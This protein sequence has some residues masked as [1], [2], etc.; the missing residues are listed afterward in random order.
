MVELSREFYFDNIVGGKYDGFPA[1]F[2]IHT[3]QS[4]NPPKNRDVRLK[5]CF[6]D[7][8]KIREFN[9]YTPIIGTSYDT[10]DKF[11][12]GDGWAYNFPKFNDVGSA[13][14]RREK[15]FTGVANLDDAFRLLRMEVMSEGGKVSEPYFI[16]PAGREFLQELKRLRLE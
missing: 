11:V 5:E 13:N 12:R 1:G 14:Y 9:G 4:A 2:H 10:H 15:D 3:K 7:H 6:M 16:Y 8:E